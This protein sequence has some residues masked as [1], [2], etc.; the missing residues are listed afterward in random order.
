ML[1]A[2]MAPGVNA[3]IFANMYGRARRVAASS[4]LLATGLSIL[5]VWGWLAVL[6]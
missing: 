4:V 6:P 2:A 3:Y 5:T 1:T